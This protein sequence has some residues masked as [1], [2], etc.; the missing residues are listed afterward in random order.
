MTDGIL[1]L[2][3]PRGPTSHDVVT[4]VR[5]LTGIRRVGHAGTLDPLA[6][7]VLLV[8]LDGPPVWPSI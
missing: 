5:A 1:N 3:K 8:A 2:D 6:T 4:R 7:G